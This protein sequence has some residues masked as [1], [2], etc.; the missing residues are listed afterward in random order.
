MTRLGVAVLLGVVCAGP[1]RAAGISA[2]SMTYKNFA[3]EAADERFRDIWTATGFRIRA[4]KVRW[5][6]LTDL[7][8]GPVGNGSHFQTQLDFLTLMLDEFNDTLYAE[9]A[10][11][12]KIRENLWRARAAA[13]EAGQPD[14]VVPTAQAYVGLRQDK[15][16]LAHQLVD[17]SNKVADAAKDL[18]ARGQW[19]LE[20]NAISQEEMNFYIE[21]DDIGAEATKQSADE[22]E[23]AQR[24][25]EEA[26]TD[27]VNT[28]GSHPVPGS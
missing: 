14:P 21:L 28:S 9:R 2:N 5:S 6:Y 3:R 23:K 13:M 10:S 26:Q 16:G 12:A 27:L 11:D 15:L 25:L 22:L 4:A 18:R 1:A 7:R 20:Q 24:L 17:A 19:L 8:L